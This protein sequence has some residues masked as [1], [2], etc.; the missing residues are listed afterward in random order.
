MHFLPE[1]S[2]V[3]PSVEPT[4]AARSCAFVVSGAFC[5]HFGGE[6]ELAHEALEGL[7]RLHNGGEVGEARGGVGRSIEMR[8]NC[9]NAM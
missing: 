4:Y 3:P 8:H 7:R 6:S 5:S 1:Q 2:V 9:M